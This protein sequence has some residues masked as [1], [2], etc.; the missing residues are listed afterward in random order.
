MKKIVDVEIR[1]E[2][3]QLHGLKA[4][5]WPE[6]SMLLI[7]DVHLG[8]AKHFRKNG[9]AVPEDILSVNLERI[10][11]LI[12]DFNPSRII[13]MGDLFHSVYN[14]VWENLEDYIQHHSSISF[15]LILGNHDILDPKI[16]ENS[17]LL[18]H[19]ECLVVGPFLLSHNAI[20]ETG[21]LYNIYGHI[22]P[23]I[24]LSGLGGQSLRLPCFF[25]GD[26]YSILPA[27]GGF[28]GMHRISVSLKDQI[29]A[30]AEQKVMAVVA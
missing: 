21:G 17:G 29:F 27:F 13:F 3:L 15:E 16:Y 23:C 26:E 14:E 20:E 25:F 6:Q 8:K 12:L 19:Q 28:T 22:H 18:I 7:A 2:L 4:L 9:I 5:F 24:Y 1:G 11:Q 30:I 10:D